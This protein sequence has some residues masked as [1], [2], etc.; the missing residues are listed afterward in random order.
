MDP[1]IIDL[2]L[3]ENIADL[4]I[5]VKKEEEPVAVCCFCGFECNPCSQCCGSCARSIWK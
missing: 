3:E 5:E 4:T 2:T 1:I